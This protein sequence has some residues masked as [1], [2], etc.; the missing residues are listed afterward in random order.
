M[1]LLQT[2]STILFANQ[3]YAAGGTNSK[4][5]WLT[6]P[7]WIRYIALAGILFGVSCC[8]WYV[9]LT[10]LHLPGASTIFLAGGFTLCWLCII[11][12]FNA[13][14]RSI[15]S[16]AM[17]IGM[18]VTLIAVIFMC[19][20]FPGGSAI[21]FWGIPNLFVVLLAIGF[22]THM[23]QEYYWAKRPLGWWVIAPQLSWLVIYWVRLFVHQRIYAEYDFQ[24]AIE[25]AYDTA[26]SEMGHAFDIKLILAYGL[27]ILPFSIWLYVV[28]K[29]QCKKTN[30]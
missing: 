21:G 24:P 7:K 2:L 9:N 19:L 5:S 27:S 17:W 28:A 26:M 18:A 16:M 1:N 14:V 11:M 29:R 3:G 20:H 22:V 13:S 8:Y 15:V 10:W 12:A 4:L 30:H 23:P 25:Y 6:Y